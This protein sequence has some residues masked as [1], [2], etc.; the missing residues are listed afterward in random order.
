MRNVN[1]LLEKQSDSLC[2]FPVIVELAEVMV[3]HLKLLNARRNMRHFFHLYIRKQNV[4][5]S[6]WSAVSSSCLSICMNCVLEAKHSVR[7]GKRL[8][9]FLK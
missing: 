6:F 5:V 3:Y 1:L 2:Y 8:T 7:E 4:G 9:T